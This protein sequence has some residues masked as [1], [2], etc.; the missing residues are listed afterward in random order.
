MILQILIVV[1]EQM[2]GLQTPPGLRSSFRTDHS[3]TRRR[4]PIV[5]LSGVWCR[6]PSS[7]VNGK[8]TRVYF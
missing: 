6:D 2:L 1:W 4:V 7:H 8:P 3:W 5:I